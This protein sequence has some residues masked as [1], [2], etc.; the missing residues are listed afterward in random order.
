MNPARRLSVVVVAYQMRREIVRT[1]QSLSPRGQKGV[2]AA[3]YEII[4]V[5]NGS[6]DP[7]TPDLFPADIPNLRVVAM[8][9]PQPSPARALNH[10][11]SL[12]EGAVIVSMIDGARMASPG[13][14]RWMIEAFTLSAIGPAIVS[15]WHIGPDVQ[16]RSVAKGYD[17][18]AED[19][20]LATIDWQGNG[21]RLFDVSQKLDPSSEPAA[22]FNPVAESNFIGVS[23]ED[24]ARL[25]GFD[26]AFTS[27]GGGAV[28]LDFFKRAVEQLRRPVVSL[29][30]EGTFHQVHGGVST[31]VAEADHPWDA[32]HDE[33]R[34]I[35]GHDFAEPAYDPILL[36]QLE[37]H[38][39]AWLTR[40]RTIISHAMRPC[41]I[42]DRIVEAARVLRGEHAFLPAA[43]RR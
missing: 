20:L 29:I 40:N 33:Y 37:A 19:A 16:N 5:D 4:V 24:Y 41:G 1:V 31:N 13:C 11:A 18:A 32:I 23:R 15:S 17:R 8:P 38:G 14:V 25:G 27:A 2:T 28:N 36:G 35:R 10:G 22:W 34:A 42:K 26:E 9:D 6:P 43:G 30:G 39:R 21:Y 7:V 12:A 3:D